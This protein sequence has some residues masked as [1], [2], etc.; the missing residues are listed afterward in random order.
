MVAVLTLCVSPAAADYKIEKAG[1]PPEELAPA[2]R[3]SLAPEGWRVVGPQGPLCEVWIRRVVPAKASAP[4]ELGIAFSELA[5]G[6]LVGAVRFLAPAADYRRVRVK[7]GV[8]TMRYMLHPTDGNHMGVAPERDFLLLSPAGADTSTATVPANDLLALSRK[9][10]GI[11]HPTVWRLQ[12][13][14]GSAEP[15]LVHAEEEDQWVLQFEVVLQPAGG[16]A[17]KKAM[18]MVVVGSAPEA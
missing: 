16:A 6:T 5:E 10:V 1:A 3:E 8:Y 14:T 4:Q 12:A 17:V 2:I 13:M 18:G 11:N 7:P 15:A 9:A